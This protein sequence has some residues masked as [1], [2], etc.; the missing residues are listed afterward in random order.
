MPHAE[1]P[2]RVVR[3]PPRPEVL[4]DLVH[5]LASDTAKIKWSRHALE[6]M[7]ERSITDQMTIE[8]L[9]FGSLKGDVVPGDNPDELIVK[10]VRQIKGHREVGVVVVT[11]KSLHLLVKTVE[12]EDVR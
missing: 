1:R 8:V 9:R 12:W 11:V 6:R 7:T 5:R 10:M 4:R 3:L 2:D